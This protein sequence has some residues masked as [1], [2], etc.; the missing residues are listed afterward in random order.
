VHAG[1]DAGRGSLLCAGDLFRMAA[2]VV[3]AGLTT[4][5]LAEEP[6]PAVGIGTPK[7]ATPAPA[8]DPAEVQSAWWSW[9]SGSPSGRNP[10]EDATGEHCAEGQPSD[11]WF[12]AGT[13]GG[14]A[15]RRCTVPPGRALI[16]PLVNRMGESAAECDSCMRS[17]QGA[18]TIDGRPWP[19]LRWNATPITVTATAGNPVTGDEGTF[20]GHACGLWSW[21]P[22]LPPART[23]WSSAATARAFRYR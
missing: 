1:P 7:T 14:S 15:T 18:L 19:T 9:A 5:C 4:G 6:R 11:R 17:A 20:G 21:S 16:A 2:V 13:F 3:A 8:L 23:G 12:L 10:V 22:P